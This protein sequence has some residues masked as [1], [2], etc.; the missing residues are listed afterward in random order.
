MR[1]CRRCR[2]PIEN[3]VATC[4][5]CDTA[6]EEFA[7]APSQA[8][9]APGTGQPG[10]DPHSEPA[11]RRNLARQLL[12]GLADLILL[13]LGWPLPLLLLPLGLV[14]AIGYLFAGQSGATISLVA[15]V[16]LLFVLV[17]WSEAGG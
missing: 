17:V 2:A 10:V 9:P 11:P 15:A 4:P 13:G 6:Q 7:S 16:L 8:K 5:H 14:V 12:R 3:N 1:P